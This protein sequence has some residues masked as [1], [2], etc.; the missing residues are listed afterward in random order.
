[1]LDALLEARFHRLA[2]GVL[3]SLCQLIWQ[4]C[5][6][7]HVMP[8]QMTADP[9]FNREESLRKRL[10]AFLSLSF[11]LPEHDYYA[12]LDT[13]SFLSLK[14]VLAD[15][16][17]ILTLRVALAFIDWV[18]VRLNL[19][20]QAKLELERIF[21]NSKPN[22]NGFDVWLGYPVA[23][24]GEVKCN[25]PI[26]KG[27]IYGAQQRHG[28]EKD[29]TS[30]LEGKRKASFNP[31]SCLKFLAFLDRPEIRSANEHLLRTSKVCKGR[32]EFVSGN[33]ELNRHDIIYGV[34]VAPKA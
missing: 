17:N 4:I 26:N 29:V 21:L 11:E 23:F 18:A 13:E 10:N 3:D 9:I 25:V 6:L 8:L 19:D 32:L 27:S 16:N 28:I 7:L 20:A 1:M 15:I 34:Y 22:S 31:Q 33:T 30:L 24:V 2:G 12:K 5:R 14:S